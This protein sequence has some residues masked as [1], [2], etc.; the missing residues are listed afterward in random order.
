MNTTKEIT[1][2]FQIVTQTKNS[3]D[4]N[5]QTYTIHM[6]NV[7]E[8]VESF[9]KV[10]SCVDQHY[11][12]HKN[13]G[14]LENYLGVIYIPAWSEQAD[15]LTPVKEHVDNARKFIQRVRHHQP[16]LVTF[17]DILIINRTIEEVITKTEETI[18][19]GEKYVI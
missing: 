1:H 2:K 14:D 9:I 8:L 6:T 13:L 12:K 4:D 3:S 17:K 15:V 10:S 16:V 19:F 7:D 18:L 5:K 11:G